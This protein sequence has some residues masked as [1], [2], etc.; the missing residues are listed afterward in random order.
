MKLCG[1]IV[2]A[3][4]TWGWKAQTR[5]CLDGAAHTTLKWPQSFLFKW[6]LKSN[7]T[8]VQF[9]QW[10]KSCQANERKRARKQENYWPAQN[11]SMKLKLTKLTHSMLAHR[12]ANRMQ[13]TF[14]YWM[15]HLK[16]MAFTLAK[17]QHKICQLSDRSANFEFMVSIKGFIDAFLC[18]TA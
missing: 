2:S 13:L 4:A 14:A 18:S 9:D 10:P 6:S 16:V 12:W 15:H 3:M 17:Y 8:K 7:F 5:T 1:F 11:L